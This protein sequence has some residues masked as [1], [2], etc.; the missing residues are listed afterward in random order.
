MANSRVNFAGTT[1]I[2]RENSRGEPF[3]SCFAP[4]RDHA[5]HQSLNFVVNSEEELNEVVACGVVELS[6][7]TTV[8]KPYVNE[9]GD[10]L[11]ELTT[12]VGN[13]RSRGDW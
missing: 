10:E 3:W 11:K 9:A 7:L 6:E 2:P 13:I 5:N 12:N 4:I 8:E 1:A